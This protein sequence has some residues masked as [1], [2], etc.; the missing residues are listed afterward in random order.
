MGKGLV[1]CL[2]LSVN[3]EFPTHLWFFHKMSTMY[4]MTLYEESLL[5]HFIIASRH[6]S[7]FYLPIPWTPKSKSPLTKWLLDIG[8]IND[9]GLIRLVSFLLMSHSPFL[10]SFGHGLPLFPIVSLTP[11]IGLFSFTVVMVNLMCQLGHNKLGQ[12]CGQALVY[13]LLWRYFVDV[14]NI[15]NQ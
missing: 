3:C 8:D 1:M 4:W 14:I 11:K 12:L 2:A 5:K 6:I 7:Y 10:S 15:Y 13:M 9:I